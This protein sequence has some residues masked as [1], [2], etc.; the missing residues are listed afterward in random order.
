MTADVSVRFP[1]GLITE[2]YPQASQI[3]PAGQIG[4]DGSTLIH[5]PANAAILTNSGAFWR[6]IA[7]SPQQ[8]GALPMNLSASHYFAAREAEADLIESR[9][10]T[11]EFEKFLF[12]RG[13]GNFATPL[14]V[15][16]ASNDTVT[17]RNNGN[18]GLADLFFISIH[19][20]RGEFASLR[21]LPPS[22]SVSWINLNET[23][24]GAG[25]SAPLRQFQQDIGRK[26][27]A[28]LVSH[29]L[30]PAEARAMVDTWKDSWFGEEGDRILYLLPA[31]W[32]AQVLPMK[33]TPAPAELIRVMVGR[34]EILPPKLEARLAAD[35]NAARKGDKGA[36]AAALT[37][38]RGLGRFAEPALRLAGF[39]DDPMKNGTLSRDLLAELARSQ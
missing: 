32:T 34:T 28:A 10:D 22:K 7:I 17:V 19:G 27:A 11:N 39:A 16:V 18:Q 1:Q 33:L 37:E 38:L 2:W 14:C 21:D 3:G 13:A 29:G 35:V 25:K 8:T 20:E 4:P 23:N 36:R 24:Q 26:V 31:E 15:T 30:Y 9:T 5:S 6:N 12:Y